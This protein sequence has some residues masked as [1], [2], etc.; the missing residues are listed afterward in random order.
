MPLQSPPSEKQRIGIVV[1]LNEESA[2]AV[3]WAVSNCIR[4]QDTVILLH[5]QPTNALYGAD[6]GDTVTHNYKMGTTDMQQHTADDG[7][8]ALTSSKLVWPLL[9][10]K[11]PYKIHSVKDY[12]RKERICLDAER[13]KLSVL[14]IGSQ[15]TGANKASS[16]TSVD[17]VSEYCVHHCECPVVVVRYQGG[18]KVDVLGDRAAA[19]HLDSKI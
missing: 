10:A 8:E 19:L 13:L 9:H 14:V 12:D 7:F 15:G 18:D 1:D 16:K 5:V 17:S 3:N 11:I 2:H 4:P 6:W